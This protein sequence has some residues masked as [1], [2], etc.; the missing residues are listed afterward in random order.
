MNLRRQYT[1]PSCTLTLEG[2]DENEAVA[3]DNVD[4]QESCIS[5]LTSAECHFLASNQRLVGGRTFLENL[6]SAA[7]NYAQEYLSGISH[8]QDGQT[9][10][11]QVQ[12]YST[13][14]KDIHNLVLESD[15]Q[16][17][18]PKQEIALKTIE[19]FDLVEVVDS[20]YTDSQ[21]LPNLSLQLEVASKSF[22]QPEEPLAQRAIPLAAGTGV[23]AIAAGL[24]FMLPIPKI[25]APEP[26]LETSPIEETIPTT[27]KET[28]TED[29]S[30]TE[31]P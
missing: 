19:L 22:R 25:D 21:T 14:S 4:N 7:S 27:P 5:I 24:F 12:I 9:E 10:Y 1:K 3:E 30:E 29:S 16:E 28:T 31:T 11:P 18:Q 26:V 13:D 23:L 2:F 8:P 15:P 6:A 17:G 20:V